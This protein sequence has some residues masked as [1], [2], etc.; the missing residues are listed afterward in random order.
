MND[1]SIEVLKKQGFFFIKKLK[2]GTYKA[3]HNKT[4]YYNL[5]VEGET[6]KQN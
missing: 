5:Y 1:P 6:V 4:V 3:Q 2:N